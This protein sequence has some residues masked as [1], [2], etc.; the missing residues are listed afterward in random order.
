MAE[1]KTKPT[2]TS[3]ADYIASK[4]NEQQRS[5]CQELMALLNEITREPPKM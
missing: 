2:D 4:A 1:N 3:V 5:D